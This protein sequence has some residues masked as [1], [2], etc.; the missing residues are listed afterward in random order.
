MAVEQE[1]NKPEL[2]DLPNRYEKDYVDNKN[3]NNSADSDIDV[4]NIFLCKDV[5]R[6]NS[7]SKRIWLWFYGIGVCVE[8]ALYVVLIK[9]WGMVKW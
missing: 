5:K 4:D 9:L 6:K 1:V 8:F 7:K 2:N 3:H